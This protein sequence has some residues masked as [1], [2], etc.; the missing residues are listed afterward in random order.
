MTGR[1]VSCW[2]SIEWRREMCVVGAVVLSWGRWKAVGWVGG[3]GDKSAEMIRS[4]PNCSLATWMAQ[5]SRGHNSPGESLQSGRL[6]P[7]LQQSSRRRKM[8]T[9]A[10]SCRRRLDDRPFRA[11]GVGG[12]VLTG[13]SAA[14]RLLFFQSQTVPVSTVFTSDVAF[15]SLARI[16]GDCWTVHFPPA[17]V[18]VC[19]LKW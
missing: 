12:S 17:L 16:W 9:T 13:P 19:L 3:D 2:Q 14:I 10:G 18:F 11:E 1:M 15:S 5:L 6:S 4:C 7:G 8:M